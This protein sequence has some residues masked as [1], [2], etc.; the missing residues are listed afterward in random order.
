MDVALGYASYR[1][2]FISAE[3]QAF[4]DN[5]TAFVFLFNDY[6]ETH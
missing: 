4:K 5:L 1:K 3:E 2:S 6:S